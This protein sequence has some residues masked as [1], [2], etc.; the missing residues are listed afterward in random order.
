MIRRECRMNRVKCI[1][2]TVATV[3]L[4]NILGIIPSD[5]VYASDI[6]E[7]KTIVVDKEE[8]EVRVINYDFTNNQYISLNDLSRAFEGT[9]KAF[10]TEW[11]T[12]DG[13]TCVVINW[14][15]GDSDEDDGDSYVDMPDEPEKVS[16]SRKRIFINIDGNDYY[17]Y[18]IP[19]NEK[20][21]KDCYV[22][23]GE[24]ALSMNIDISYVDDVVYINP[25]GEFDF[26]KYDMVES[27]LSCMA[28]SCLVGDITTGNVFYS[29]NADEVVS[30]AST[31]K[32]MTYLII[33]DAMKKGEITDHDTVTFSK[34]ASELSETSDGVVKVK[35]GQTADIMDVI[36]AML[37]VSSNE[38]SLALAE[39]LCGDEETFVQRMN[40]KAAALGLSE[41]VEFYNPHGLPL[42]HENVLTPKLQNHLTANDMFKLATHILNTYPEITDITSIKKTKLA[43]LNNFEASNTNMLLYNVPGT[44]GL[45][46]GTT[47]KAASCL[48]S[49]YEAKD[50]NQETHYIVSIVYGAENGQTQGYM[51][52]VLM[53]YG[54]QKFN[55]MELGITPKRADSDEIPEDLEGMIGAVINTARRHIK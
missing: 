44:V 32:L 26:N 18:A 50:M 48:V 25:N 33:K 52:M 31:T 43:S 5:S 13:V 16:Y 1:A 39:H 51:S 35:E 55:A 49:A 11:T 28:D 17:L 6:R 38:C 29:Q 8:K 46:T 24:L 27:G 4:I 42:Y 14:D 53:R 22:N 7:V 45:K 23:C 3:M 34:K 30:I 15:R 41:N 40:Q 9:E 47:D 19:V 21:E 36:S 10:D 54:I 12:K 20:N 2:L 37:I